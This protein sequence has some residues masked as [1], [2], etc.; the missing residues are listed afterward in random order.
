MIFS[1]GN[2]KQNRLEKFLEA[3][4]DAYGEDPQDA[5]VKG[6]K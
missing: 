5:V 6:K 3:V 1:I 4:R 2:I